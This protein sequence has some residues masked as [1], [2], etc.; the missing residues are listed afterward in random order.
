METGSME[1]VEAARPRDKRRRR[2]QFCVAFVLESSFANHKRCC[3]QVIQMHAKVK[4]GSGVQPVF[5]G[6]VSQKT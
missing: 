2:C 3:R 1:E 5:L 6:G 4:G